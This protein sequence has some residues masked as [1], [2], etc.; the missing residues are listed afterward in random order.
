MV[1]KEMW[2]T[3]VSSVGAVNNNQLNSL[4]YTTIT[5]DRVNPIAQILF[6][7]NCV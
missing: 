5:H 7:L 1:E 4:N 2:T 3:L 6:N